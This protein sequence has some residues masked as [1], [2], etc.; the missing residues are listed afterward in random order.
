M[1]PEKKPL[2]L[3]DDEKVIHDL[4]LTNIPNGLTV[5]VELKSLSSLSNKKWDKAFK[6][7]VNKRLANV[8]KDGDTI[9]VGLIG[10][11][12]TKKN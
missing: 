7:V 8:K 5:L 6:G 12:T 9:T 2:D 4:L 3:T 10:Q 1:K 11:L